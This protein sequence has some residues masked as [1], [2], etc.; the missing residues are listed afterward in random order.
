MGNRPQREHKPLFEYSG[1]YEQTVRTI[2]LIRKIF[3]NA[4]KQ[5]LWVFEPSVKRWFS[6]EEFM[7]MYERYDNLDPKWIEKIEVRDPMEGLEAAD[8]QVES[9]LARKA[10]LTK[11]IIDYERFKQKSK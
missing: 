7:E 4:L 9:I 10:I 3:N 11:K 8:T 2:D 6:P 1:K 5:R